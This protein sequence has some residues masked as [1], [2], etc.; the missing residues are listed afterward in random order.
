MINQSPRHLLIVNPIASAGQ[1]PVA[2][3]VSR[4]VAWRGACHRRRFVE[5]QFNTLHDLSER[6]AA[7][8][9]RSRL[10][11]I[12][13]VCQQKVRVA[14]KGKR[15]L[16]SRTSYFTRVTGL[17]RL[18]SDLYTSARAPAGAGRRARVNIILLL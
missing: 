5:T 7:T 4:A 18:S 3:R 13:C 2:R 11:D 6:G 15:R 10:V 17:S 16:I 8:C 14:R 12:M 1:V 9:R